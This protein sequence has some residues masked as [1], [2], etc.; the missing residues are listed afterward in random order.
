MNARSANAKDRTVTAVVVIYVLALALWA[1]GLIVLGAIVAPTVFGIV[2]APTSADAMTVVFRKFDV[3]AIGSA[4][5]VLV[6]EALLAWRGGKPTRSDVARAAA[7]ILAAVLAIIEGAY[8]SPAIQALHR[9]GAIRGYGDAGR[10][11]E[12]FHRLAESAA[13]IE[14]VLLLTVVLLIVLRAR[15]PVTSSGAT[16]S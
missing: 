2:P 11:L 14:L 12:R 4:V 5:V 10:A 6:S 8:L 13:K 9:E 7:A 3:V 1:G 16:Q 15:R